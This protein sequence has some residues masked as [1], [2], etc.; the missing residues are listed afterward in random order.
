MNV[1]SSVINIS[2]I[3]GNVVCGWYAKCQP[4]LLSKQRTISTYLTYTRFSQFKL[5]TQGKLV[6]LLI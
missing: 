3:C 1:S 2:H 5:Y 6:A 4:P